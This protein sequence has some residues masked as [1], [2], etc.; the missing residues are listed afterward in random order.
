M[1]EELKEKNDRVERIRLSLL[2]HDPSNISVLFP[3][4]FPT[5]VAETER[6][7]DDAL[8]GNGPVEFHTSMSTEDID[9]VLKSLGMS[10]SLTDQE[11]GG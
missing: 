1:Q 9:S 7:I 2:A 8:S 6:E 11:L 10:G 5:T 4:L 3:D